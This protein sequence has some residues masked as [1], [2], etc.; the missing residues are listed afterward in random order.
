MAD[1]RST[2]AYTEQLSDLQNFVAP[3][4]LD[5]LKFEQISQN[6]LNSQEMRIPKADDILCL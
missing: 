1:V 2:A 5:I 6:I 3:L 4:A